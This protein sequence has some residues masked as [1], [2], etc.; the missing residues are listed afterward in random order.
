MGGLAQLASWSTS[1]GMVTAVVIVALQIG[2]HYAAA[3]PPPANELLATPATRSELKAAAPSGTNRVTVAIVF[4][5]ATAAAGDVVTLFVKM[6]IASG[7]WIY[8]L[9]D[10]GSRNVATVLSTPSACAPFKATGTWRSVPPKVKP[11]GTRTYAGEVLFERRF[12]IEPTAGGGVYTLP[13][14][15]TYQVC[16]EVLCWPPSSINLESGLRVLQSR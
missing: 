16:N 11:D 1:S 7:H 9:E 2:W 6:R 8:A 4:Q 12:Q 3:D 15:I 14:T 5:P 13:V 10:S